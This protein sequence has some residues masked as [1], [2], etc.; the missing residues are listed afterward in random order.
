[1]SSDVLTYTWKKQYGIFL[2]C[3]LSPLGWFTFVALN[4][5]RKVWSHPVIVYSKFLFESIAI[6]LMLPFKN[7]LL[8]NIIRQKAFVLWVSTLKKSMT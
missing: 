5:L 7:P 4:I 2:H 6:L 8:V 1:M 3:V